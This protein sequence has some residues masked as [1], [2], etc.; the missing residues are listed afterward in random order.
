MD[1]L[2]IL[3]CYKMPNKESV[4]SPFIV[5]R[6][7]LINADISGIVSIETEVLY[8]DSV[9]TQKLDFIIS[10]LPGYTVQIRSMMRGCLRASIKISNFYTL[11]Y[12]NVFKRN[13]NVTT[14][15]LIAPYVMDKILR[16]VLY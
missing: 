12:I 15:S 13:T 2:F 10:R 8:K 4:I 1:S 6:E 11:E 3:R 16:T 9:I 7:T 5:E 14:V